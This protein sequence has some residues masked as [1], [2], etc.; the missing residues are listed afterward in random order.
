MLEKTSEKNKGVT[1]IALT[2]TI[3]I[4]IILAGVSIATLTGDNGI[5]SKA[6]Q[7]KD[8]TENAEKE[9]QKQIQ[10][11]Y[12]S[13]NEKSEIQKMEDLEKDPN[14]YRHPDQ[15]SDNKDSA[16]GTDD[17]PV[18]LSL[19][20]YELED[21]GIGIKLSITYNSTMSLPG[22]DNENVTSDGKIIGKVPKYI[23]LDAVKKVYPVT[24]MLETFLD[25]VD[26]REAPEIP[27]T[28]TNL[29]GTFEG[30]TNLMTASS[31]PEKVVTM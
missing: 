24:S 16:I 14:Q 19:W 2:V 23:Y 18:N 6:K 31:I 21:S 3:I 28:V 1:L 11:I 30:C 29:I 9:E 8:D 7:A 12:D 26:L 13:I 5:I 27:I 20:K 10:D 17:Q 22:Y 4:L 15:K 25:C